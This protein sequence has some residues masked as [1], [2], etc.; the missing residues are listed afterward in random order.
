MTTILSAPLEVQVGPP[1][2]ASTIERANALPLG[3]SGSTRPCALPERHDLAVRAAATDP[4]R[5]A[6]SQR[7]SEL[8]T[9]LLAA[10]GKGLELGDA[11]LRGLNLSGFDLRGANLNRACLHD[12]N[13]SR[14]DLA[15]ASM[16]CAG[17][18]RTKLDGAS[19]RG[20]YVHAMAA[21]VCSFRDADLSGLVDATGSLFHGCPMSG[22]KLGGSMLSGAM[23]Y[24]CDLERAGFQGANLQGAAINECV[25]DAADFRS[26]L[27][28]QLTITKCR[29]R[30]ANFSEASGNGLV[31]QRLTS[32]DELVLDNAHLPSLRLDGLA[33]VGVSGRSLDA[34]SADVL[35][36][37][38]EAADFA[39]ASLCASRWLSCRMPGIDLSGAKLEEAM[40]RA[41]L[42]NG[43]NF[44][45]TLCENVQIVE[46]QFQRARM[47]KLGGRC[48]TIRDTAMDEVDLR[49]AYLYRAVITGDPPSAAA[50]TNADL[51]SANLVQAYVNSNLRGADM[52]GANLTYARLNQ[53]NLADADLSGCNMFQ[54]SMVKVNCC[55][56]RFSGVSAP[57]FF[58]RCGGLKEALISSENVDGLLSFMGDLE[59]VMRSARGGST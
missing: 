56:A 44:E 45:A 50:M 58:D 36:C 23:F 7:I 25:V 6:A 41:C 9:A 10:T 59:T 3:N 13:L 37:A 21:Q 47:A 16:V 31:L 57:V 11:D 52:R 27:V 46:C 34:P 19:M 53:A 32:C 8:T 1:A 15:Q 54:A 39:R 5:A 43:A 42:F 2:L 49:E 18:E 33:G 51:R 22:V 48:V 40:F 28:S 4:D 35:S 38:F 30:G 14:C 26:A 20:A 55:G 29:M 24:Q 12:T 17:M